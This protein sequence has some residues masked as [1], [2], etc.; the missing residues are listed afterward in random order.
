MESALSNT[1][2]EGIDYGPL[3]HLIGTWEGA[4]GMDVSPEPD[5]DEHNPYYETIRF[6]AAGDV[7]NAES[8]VLVIVRYH[9]VVKR[10]SNNKVFHDQIGYWLWDAKTGVVMQSVSIPRGVTL[11]AGGQAEAND[12]NKVTF[13]VVATEGESDWGITQSPF[14]KDNARTVAFSHTLSVDGDRLQYSETTLLDIYGKS[15]YEH[16]DQNSLTRRQS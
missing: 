4:D 5:D 9:Q 11:L 14:M 3:F 2:I 12:G 15:R 6:E 1:E 16:T 13:K 10:K 8:Q 7:T